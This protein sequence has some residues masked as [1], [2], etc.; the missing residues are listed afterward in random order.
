MLLGLCHTVV[1]E[2]N[3]DYN[4]SSPDELAFSYFAKLVGAEFLG[5]DEDN[6]IVLDE[7]GT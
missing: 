5:M 6:N 7:F 4:A 2:K 1:L 3:G